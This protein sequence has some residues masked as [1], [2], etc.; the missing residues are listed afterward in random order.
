MTSGLPAKQLYVTSRDDWRS[1]LAAHHAAEKEM[2]LVFYRE[3]TGRPNIPYEDAVEEAICYGWIDSLVRK[4]DE[5]RYARKFTPRTGTAVWSA[6][7]KE[8]VARLERGGRLAEAGRRVIAE[9]K[10]NGS[11]YK[12]PGAKVAWEMP[13]EFEQ[14]LAASA[15]ARENFEKL[16]PSHRRRYVGWIASAKQTETRARRAAEAVSR[17]EKNEKLGL[18]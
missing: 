1:W 15:A 10:R 9:A 2:W 3:R 11:W 6:L 14:A 12:V 16:A 7:N 13:A 5:E 18:K 4:L 17:L 8:R